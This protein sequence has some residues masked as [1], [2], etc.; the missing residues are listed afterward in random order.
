MANH[1]KVPSVISVGTLLAS[2]FER[3]LLITIHM[4]Q[5]ASPGPDQEFQWGS[6]I[7]DEATT[8]VHTKLELDL[9]EVTD[10]LDFMIQALD[11]MG[12]LNFRNIEQSD[13]PEYSHRSP[14]EV[15]TDYLKQVFRFLEHDIDLFKSGVREN[16]GADI[17]VTI[18][19]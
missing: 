17:V 4:I 6:N 1:D 10:E 12:N 18:R 7:S 8:M 5:Y 19:W 16:F 9:Y 11:G 15:V 13:F 14:Q 2:H 3:T